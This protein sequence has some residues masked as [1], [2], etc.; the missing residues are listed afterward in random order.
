ML[1]SP[2][3]SATDVPTSATFTWEAS[4]TASNYRIQ[5]A[6]D[7]VF[8]LIQ[9]DNASLTSTTFV[10]GTE[11]K[12]TTKYFWHLVAINAGGGSN[13]S[14]TR[15][16]TTGIAVGINENDFV[17][18]TFEIVPNPFNESTQIKFSIAERNLVSVTIFDLLGRKIS[19][20]LDDELS[21]GEYSLNFDNSPSLI[22]NNSMLL[23]RLQI[24]NRV[25]VKKMIYLP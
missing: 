13:W 1:T 9:T 11:L 12:P 8:H 2:A 17:Q 18:S 20:L 19:N 15:S 16:F 10:V 5:I 6:E 14:E 25:Y 21:P 7:Y 3:D 24:G 23:C 4:A 22:N